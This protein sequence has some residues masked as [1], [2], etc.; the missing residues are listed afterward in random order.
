MVRIAS[1]LWG[2]TRK[3]MVVWL[4]AFGFWQLAVHVYRKDVG[5]RSLSQ[6]PGETCQIPKTAGAGRPLGLSLCHHSNHSKGIIILA[7]FLKQRDKTNKGE[8]QIGKPLH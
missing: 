6:K 7:F 5:N 3:M 1:D 8:R 4:L 2:K